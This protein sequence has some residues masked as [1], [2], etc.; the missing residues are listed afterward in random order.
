MSS[1]AIGRLKAWAL[2][3][4][5]AACLPAGARAAVFV[6]HNASGGTVTSDYL[7][8]DC[9]QYGG[10]QLN[11]DGSVRRRI[12]TAQQQQA[13]QAQQ[14]REQAQR[15]HLL[16]EQRR[17]R[18]LLG[19]YPDDATLRSAEKDDLHSVQALID[20]AQQRLKVLARDRVHLEQDAQFYPNGNYPEGLRSRMRMNQSQ[21]V[22]EQQL[23][24]QQQQQ[25]QEI[26]Q[27]YAALRER[28]Q[29]LWARAAQA[30]GH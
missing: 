24:Q 12:L 27:R 26:R 4:A 25:M 1:L 5:L 13:Q 19:R 18:A 23:V 29:P 20:A 9:L 17:Q 6:C 16:R 7:S 22:Q 21:R 10:K 14:S 2:C 3:G 28:L 30:G 11:P 8:S 15:E